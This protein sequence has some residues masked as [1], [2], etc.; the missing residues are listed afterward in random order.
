MN[1]LDFENRLKLFQVSNQLLE[2]DLDAIEH[3]FCISLGRGIM[4]DTEFDTEYYPQIDA[5]IRQE[6]QEMSASYE[7][8]YSL[9]K[10]IRSFIEDSFEAAGI[11]DW[12]NEECVP[13]RVKQET[14]SRIEREIDSGVTPRSDN[15]IDYT[16]FGELGEIIKHN[17]AL[18]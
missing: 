6:A 1:S 15:P 12:W 3:R 13:E 14:E 7:V 18:R 11:V 17:W 2:N 9:E 16:T 5:S 4:K 8:F 10:A